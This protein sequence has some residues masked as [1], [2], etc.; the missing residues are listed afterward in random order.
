MEK[1]VKPEFLPARHLTQNIWKRDTNIKIIK[2]CSL[3]HSV[4][5][6]LT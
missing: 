5:L 6:F 2:V 1:Q 4:Y 3:I